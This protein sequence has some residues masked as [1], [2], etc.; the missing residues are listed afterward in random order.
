MSDG[1]EHAVDADVKAYFQRYE[2]IFDSEPWQ[3]LTDEWR[4]DLAEIPVRA[5]FDAKSW[6]EILAARAVVQ[7][8]SEYLTYPKQIELRKQAIMVERERIRDDN[9]DMERP[10]V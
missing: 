1:E 3:L 7:K 9:R 10:D 2:T 4:R 5:F 8:L 6:D